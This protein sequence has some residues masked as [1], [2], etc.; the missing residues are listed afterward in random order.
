MTTEKEEKK[1]MNIV[2]IGDAA[3]ALA[4]PEKALYDAA[5]EG[6]LDVFTRK[7][8]RKTYYLV[9]PAEAERWKRDVYRPR[10]ARAAG[11]VAR[12]TEPPTGPT[13]QALSA[14]ADATGWSAGEIVDAA[15]LSF[16]Q[17]LGVL[18]GAP[19]ENQ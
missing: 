13:H 14:I 8:G 7:A 15:I 6:K 4:V 5:R 16:A 1:P 11:V 17:D 12:R 3:K 9:A 18:P 2:T 19:K 10:P